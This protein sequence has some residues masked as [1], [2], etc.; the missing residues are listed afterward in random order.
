MTAEEDTQSKFVHDAPPLLPTLTSS[1][2]HIEWTW[3]DG[4]PAPIRR[5]H[6]AVQGEKVY[7]TGGNSPN[8]D[9]AH[10]VFVYKIDD[11]C[12]G[13][14]PTPDHYLTVPHII[15][16]KLT[17]IGGRLIV[18][19]KITN[20]ISTFDQAKQSWVSHYPNLLSP[21]NK[22]G[23]V[24]HMEY[25]I[26]AGGVK[27]ESTPVVLD[28]IEILDWI[29][30]SQW[31]K[32]SLHLPVPMCALQLIVS[33]D[34]VFIVGYADTLLYYD[35]R[36]YQLPVTVITNSADQQCA[37]TKWVELGEATHRHSSVVTGLSS[38]MVAGGC[39]AT[40]TTADI[41]MYDKSTQKWKKI[42]SLSFP[43]YSTAAAA[44]NNNS[45]III[46][47]CTSISAPDSTC[48]TVVELGQVGQV[49]S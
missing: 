28:D 2:Y 30:N 45:I 18:T 10:Q 3:L 17:L 27:G 7:V 37:S 16:G 26:V 34:T 33:D 4:L 5:A 29:E 40:D 49:V 22:P 12:W 31:R 41:K 23:V 24:A 14:L 43:K 44:I 46:G 47:G 25:A 20:K 6:V 8:E 1:K 9:A 21:R 19:K 32:A 11:D 35:K 36:A 15:G 48:L 39:D 13:Q 42:D 38:L